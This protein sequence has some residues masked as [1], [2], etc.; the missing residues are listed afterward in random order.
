MSSRLVLTVIAYDISDNKARSALARR[1]EKRAVRVQESV[2]EAH[3]TRAGLK[4]LMAQLERYLSPGDSLRAYPVVDS[5]VPR[6]VAMGV[7]AP[8]HGG[9]YWLV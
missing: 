8:P 4:R 9:D 7:G 5:S 2:F 1:L 3:L 6:C